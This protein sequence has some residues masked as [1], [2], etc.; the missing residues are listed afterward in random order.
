MDIGEV[1]YS[2]FYKWYIFTGK[3][4]CFALACENVPYTVSDGVLSATMD[5][6]LLDPSFVQFF[7]PGEASNAANLTFSC[8]HILKL[9]GSGINDAGQASHSSYNFGDPIPGFAFDGG[10]IFSGALKNSENGKEGSYT[11]KIVDSKGTADTFDD[12]TYILT[13]TTTLNYTDAILLP[14]LSEWSVPVPDLVDLGLGVK[15]ATFN[16]GASKPEEYGKYYAWGETEP[17]SVYSWDNYFDTTDGG[18][19]FTKYATDKKKVLDPEDDVASVA[20]YDSK[21]AW[22]IYSDS[23]TQTF[24]LSERFSGYPVRPVSD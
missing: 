15:W 21:F 18:S 24:F 5:M 14:A 1:T 8:E 12:E 11:L 4:Y 9:H 6:T 22:M 16:V 23:F 10:V 19:T 3:N 2:S 20:L 7:L 17:K 13:K